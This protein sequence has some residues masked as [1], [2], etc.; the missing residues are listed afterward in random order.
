MHYERD[1]TRSTGIFK[2]DSANG[3]GKFIVL[4]AAHDRWNLFQLG[5][6]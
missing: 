2:T 1:G 3:I 5:L 6:F 4:S